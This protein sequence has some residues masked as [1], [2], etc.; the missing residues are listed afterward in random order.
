MRIAS[1]VA[2]RNL[3]NGRAYMPTQEKKDF[4]VIA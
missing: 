1:R 2:E 3:A 4:I